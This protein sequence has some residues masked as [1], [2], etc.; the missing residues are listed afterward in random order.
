[1]DFTKQEKYSAVAYF[2]QDLI[3][4][5]TYSGFRMMAIDPDVKEL[6]LPTDVSDLELGQAALLALSESRQI[7]QSEIADYFDNTKT[8]DTYNKWVNRLIEKYKYKT[9]RALFKNMKHCMI[10]IRGEYLTIMLT[11]HEK[12]QAWS[13]HGLTKNDDVVL[14][15]D[16]SA[17]KIGAGL[18]LAFSRCRSRCR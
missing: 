12:L 7:A 2:N 3:C 13:G 16:S 5:Q 1:M 14:P 10:E 15:I 4:L 9:K 8:N 6:L 18:R 17:E 11:C